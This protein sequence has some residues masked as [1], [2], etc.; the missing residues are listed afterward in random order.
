MKVQSYLMFNGRTE[1]ALEFYKTAVGAEIEV[2]MTFDQAPEQ[3]PAGTLPAGFEKKVMHSSFRI[4]ETQLMASDGCEAAKAATFEGVALALVAANPAEAERLFK[5]LSDGGK[6]T[7]P[8]TATFFSPAFGT[9]TDRFG[10]Q[11]MVV[12]DQAASAAAAA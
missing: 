8:L 3:P 12:A 5:G 4:G 2:V 10:V 9:V 6:V 7:M 1:E 11:W